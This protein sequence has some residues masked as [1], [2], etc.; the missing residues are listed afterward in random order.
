MHPRALKE[1]S[2]EVA[3][4]LPIIVNTSWRVEDVPQNWRRVN[5]IPVFKKEGK[6]NPGNYRSVSL[7]Y[8]PGKNL[9]QILMG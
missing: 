9:E 5:V 4:P 1:L 3:E 6:V 7:T 8:I 2:R